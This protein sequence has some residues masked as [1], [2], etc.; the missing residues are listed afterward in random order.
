MSGE[1]DAS[2]TLEIPD[3]QSSQRDISFVAGR[4][5]VVSVAGVVAETLR[6]GVS[7]GGVDDLTV[8]ATILNDLKEKKI[9]ERRGSSD[10]Y[11]RWAI[12]KAL[13]LLRIHRDA[14]DSVAEDMR[15]GKSI[16]ECIETIE[17]T[18]CE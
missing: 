13:Q 9:I 12:G 3:F 18:L 14:L 2:L 10:G 8:A 1:K 6:F 7:N 17:N 5:L 15:A 4:L 16:F 11:I